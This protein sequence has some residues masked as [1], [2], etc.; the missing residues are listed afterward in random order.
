MKNVNENM[1]AAFK[2][3]AGAMFKKDFLGIIGGSISH[4]YGDNQFIINANNAVFSDIGAHNLVILSHKRDYSWQ[5]ASKD[6]EIHSQ[7]YRDFSEAKCVAY[8]IPPYSV[9]YSINHFKI[10]PKDFCGGIK[11]SELNIY[12]PKEFSSWSERADVEICNFLKQSAKNAIVIKGY[13]IYAYGRDFA[14][15]VR[16]IESIE[17]STRILMLH[18]LENTLLNYKLE[19]GNELLQ[20]EQ[21]LPYS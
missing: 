15:L 8:A 21:K 10:I 14:H 18:G 9:A 2:T 4:K 12:D 6:A 3:Y 7:I 11:F 1:L 16:T 20:G 19:L 17:Q 5:N 13:G